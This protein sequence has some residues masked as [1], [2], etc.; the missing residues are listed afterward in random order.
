M[1]DGVAVE[2]VREQ[3]AAETPKTLAARGADPTQN[4]KQRDVES[5]YSNADLVVQGQVVSVDV[6]EMLRDSQRTAMRSSAKRGVRA[7]AAVV[8]DVGPVSE[9]DPKWRDATIEI[10]AVHK[11]NHGARTI[12]VRFPSSTDVRWYKAPKFHPGDKGVWML[13]KNRTEPVSAG[14]LKSAAAAASTEEVFTALDPLDFHT[15]NA[16][17]VVAPL[18]NMPHPANA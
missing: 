5:R 12:K 11:G 15:A 17:H 8:P 6:P 4:L 9:H 16:L 10:A 14:A 1:G 3:S 2:S 18:L 13:K 7:A